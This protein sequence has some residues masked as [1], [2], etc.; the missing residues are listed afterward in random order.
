V[1]KKYIKKFES[2]HLT[3]STSIEFAKD[4]LWHSIVL[5]AF[6]SYNDLLVVSISKGSYK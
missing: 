3:C 6:A 4:V 1:G 5:F 2:N